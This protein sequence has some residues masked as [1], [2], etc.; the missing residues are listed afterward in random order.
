MG[1]VLDYKEEIERQ[2]FEAYIRMVETPENAKKIIKEI[3]KKY[4]MHIRV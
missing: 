2:S 4:N 3:K 1:K